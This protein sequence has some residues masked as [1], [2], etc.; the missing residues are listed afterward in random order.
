MRKLLAVVPVL[1]LATACVP[2]AYR[3]RVPYGHP[4]A[5]VYGPSFRYDLPV[6]PVG[7]WDN[8]MM[9]AAGTPVQ[10]LLMNGG[11]GSGGFVTADSSHLRI[12]GASGEVDFAAADVMR[13]DRLPGGSIASDAGKG[14][15]F[16]AAAVGVLGLIVGH[17]PPP[18]VF[19][20][21]AI[22]GAYQN[23]QLGRLDDRQ[24]TIYLSP[25]VAPGREPGAELRKIARPPGTD[26]RR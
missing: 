11:V 6:S 24:M 25:A 7:R 5:G 26:S 3:Q 15:A 16:G 13:L 10:V 19:A 14:A 4:G 21:G 17:V 23:A 9:L 1:M 22:S 20:A 18:R 8:V 2:A 12:R